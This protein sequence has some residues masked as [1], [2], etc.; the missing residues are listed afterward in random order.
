MS[1]FQTL[2]DD[3]VAAL[4]GAGVEDVARH[5]R[6]FKVLTRDS[7]VKVMSAEAFD[8]LVKSKVAEKAAHAT[9]ET[10]LLYPTFKY[11]DDAPQSTIAGKYQIVEV[12]SLV[13]EP[14][15]LSF[16]SSLAD[17]RLK[18][19]DRYGRPVIEIPEKNISLDYL[20]ESK[21][22]LFRGEMPTPAANV[23][24]VIARENI[25]KAQ[26]HAGQSTR[27]HGQRLT[28]GH[29][30][31]TDLSRLNPE[32]PT[33]FRG[34]IVPEVKGGMALADY[35]PK[36]PYPQIQVG[37]ETITLNGPGWYVPQSL[38]V[39]ARLNAMS[40]T[41]G[42]SA[43]V[44]DEGFGERLATVFSDP[45][46]LARDLQIAKPAARI[47]GGPGTDLIVNA[48]TVPVTR[49]AIEQSARIAGQKVRVYPLGS[50]GNFGVKFDGIERAPK[51]DTGTF[52]EA[53]PLYTSVK[54]T[55]G[56]GGEIAVP[57]NSVKNGMVEGHRTY[58]SRNAFG[59]T[60]VPI[61]RNWLQKDRMMSHLD[62]SPVYQDAA[63]T[64]DLPEGIFA[65]RLG[66]KLKT[67]D[68]VRQQQESL[69]DRPAV[70]DITRD[71]SSPFLVPSGHELAADD[72][73]TKAAYFR[74]QQKGDVN[75]WNLASSI[76][77]GY[78]GRLQ[79]VNPANPN[80]FSTVLEP[81]R[82][83]VAQRQQV[84]AKKI[85]GGVPSIPTASLNTIDDD[86]ADIQQGVWAHTSK[87]DNTIKDVPNAAMGVS[88]RESNR[89]ARNYAA[90][91]M[92]ASRRT[93]KFGVEDQYPPRAIG[94]KGAMVFDSDVADLAKD[95]FGGAQTNRD[96]NVEPYGAPVEVDSK[97]QFTKTPNGYRRV[98]TPLTDHQYADY[99]GGTPLDYQAARSLPGRVE[100]EEAS[101]VARMSGIQR[102]ALRR[103]R[104]RIGDRAPTEKEARLIQRL[105]GG[106]E[107][108]RPS[109]RI[110][111]RTT[112]TARLAEADAR[113][114]EIAH[115]NT[116]LEVA[117]DITL[118][119]DED[120]LNR[121]IEANLRAI[122]RFAAGKIS[123]GKL[124]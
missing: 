118:S 5:G 13:K 33:E 122:H 124:A 25:A 67:K 89:M 62:F 55:A 98:E 18:V 103:L 114:R 47:A 79:F 35:T 75:G 2:G 44:G 3:V 84:V 26:Q 32:L 72:L 36:L 15:A 4:R 95:R 45:T 85:A 96:I 40:A 54:M 53:G 119:A 63:G 86:F 19:G 52:K 41:A 23:Q 111:R 50:T 66:P 38:E 37:E 10:R 115:G 64:A 60:L 104:Q 81:N 57:A 21:M 48:G 99:F 17:R 76:A 43:R 61:E 70:I 31:L 91:Q 42:R 94:T 56:D 30:R 28:A 74:T 69:L 51:A 80:Q 110:D 107:Q 108:H 22:R 11:V 29:A 27:S 58:G 1:I 73:T 7:G 105:S 71:T 49:D 88:S 109:L 102:D 59:D 20:P 14:G 106:L 93:P 101:S 113:A 8:A 9:K 6:K 16:Q 92:T 117:D 87:G 68:G 78:R 24:E 46:D 82:A 83:K 116:G 34:H 100:L 112:E 65:T 121:Q 123:R 77:P 12:P 97:V 120:E 39:K 90:Q